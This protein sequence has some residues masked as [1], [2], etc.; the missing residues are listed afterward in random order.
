MMDALA[1]LEPIARPLLAEVDQALATLGAPAA[2]PVWSALRSVGATPA[3]CVSTVAA[4][5]PAPLRTAA[6]ALRAQ[7]RDYTEATPSAPPAWEG[8]A[9]ALYRARAAAI[10][11]Q[12]SA[13]PQSMAQR[14]TDQAGY[15][16]AVATWYE[17]TRSAVA[18]ALAEVLTS[19]QAVAIRTAADGTLASSVSAA[20]D[21]AT[22]LLDVVANALA[23]GE[24]LPQAWRGRL[25]R[26]DFPSAGDAEPA[27]GAIDV[28]HA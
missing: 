11:Q 8:Q 10:A 25:Q 22:H 5:D 24:D 19:S 7:A 1:R 13:G 4:W 28:H 9:G 14:L 26:L 15:A 6:N 21:M 2:H 17:Q 16:D 3:D 18:A 20:A 12:L 27:S 23:A